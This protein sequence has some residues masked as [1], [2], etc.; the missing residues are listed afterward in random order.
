MNS[1]LGE[2]TYQ[3]I[4]TLAGHVVI[5]QVSVVLYEG[6]NDVSESP[7]TDGVVVGFGKTK[8]QAYRDAMKALEIAEKAY[9]GDG[10]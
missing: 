3:V 1:I 10:E 6:D 7:V 2:A 8:K 5:C 4:E 9:S